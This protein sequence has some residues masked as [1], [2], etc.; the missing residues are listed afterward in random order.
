MP[1]SS[2]SSYYLE[3]KCPQGLMGLNSWFPTG[4]LFGKDIELLEGG[5]TWK[6]EVTG[7]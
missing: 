7:S 3:V 5:P 2:K 6:K 1:K 4:V